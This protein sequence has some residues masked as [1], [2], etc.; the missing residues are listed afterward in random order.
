M[1]AVIG[2]E[3]DFEACDFHLRWNLHHK[4]REWQ[5]QGRLDPNLFDKEKTAQWPAS[6]QDAFRPPL[7]NTRTLGALGGIIASRIA[8]EFRFG[9]PS[10]VVSSEAVS[11]LKALEIGVRSLQRNEI[12]AVLVG[13]VDLC[14]DVR[15]VTVSN[16]IRTFTQNNIIRP[17]DASADGTLPGE[18]AAAVVLKRLDQAVTD[19]DRIYS[20]VKGLGDAVGGKNPMPSKDAIVLSLKRA[21]KDAGISPSAVSLIETHGSGSPIEDRMESEALVEVFNGKELSIAVGS[22]KPNIGHTGAAAGLASMVKTSLCLYQ[23]IIP[24]L[25][26]Y[27]SPASS[28]WQNSPF[29]MPASA[30]YWVRNRSDGPR[31]ACISAM[32]LDGNCMHVVLEGVEYDDVDRDFDG[33][34]D[35]VTDKVV[36]ER[37]RPLGVMA[38]GLFVVEGNTEGELLEGLFSLS[39]HVQTSQDSNRPASSIKHHEAMDGHMESLAKSWYLKSKPE[40]EKPLAL[41]IVAENLTKLETYIDDA[42]T[43]VSTQTQRHMN[44]PGGVSY[45]PSPLGP[46][47]ETAFVYP[48]SGNHYVGMGRGIG[49]LW[50]EILRKM[51]AETSR[52]KTQL[53]PEVYIPRRTSWEGGWETEALQKI[54]SDPLNMIFGQVVHGTVMTRLA[55]GFGIRPHAVIGYSLGESAGLFAMGVWPDRGRMLKRM[56]DTN[57]F[58]TE[59][60]GPCHSARNA[61]KIPE[62]EAVNWCAAVVNRSADRVLDVIADQPFVKLLIIN[63]PDQCVIGGR[64]PNVQAVIQ[65]LKCEAVFLDG[66]VTVHCDASHPV[67]EDYKNLHL[68]PT[69][70]TE[71][72]RFYS[73]ALGRAYRPT[74]ES[75]AK[76]ILDQALSGFNFTTLIE[77]AYGDGVRIFLEMGPHASCTGMIKTILKAKPHLALSACSRGEDDLLTILKCLGTLTAHRVPVDL[78]TLYG[79]HA[80]TPTAHEIR[81]QT[82]GRRMTLPVGGKIPSP[83]LPG[84]EA[85]SPRLN[86][87]RSS[88]SKNLTG[89]AEVGRRRQINR[90]FKLPEQ[91]DTFNQQSTI[92]NHKSKIDLLPPNAAAGESRKPDAYIPYRN[93]MDSLTESTQATAKAHQAFLEFSNTITQGFEKTFETQSKLLE[94]LISEEHLQPQ[95]GPA[96]Q[97][98]GKSDSLAAHTEKRRIN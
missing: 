7:N 11:G 39:L 93:L 53:I 16:Q 47:G 2:I 26:N 23:E 19:K 65:N 28:I 35:R 15:S 55:R 70:P 98:N 68:F 37:K 62:H 30:Q 31:R 17:F 44:G 22:V 91:S 36:L 78:D 29:Y 63:T 6:L 89:Q 61:W 88:S 45:S 20:V 83:V 5:K 66:V 18:G 76:S 32:T 9:G 74:R 49:V 1:G 97:P 13:A 69:T 25:N 95:T 33:I 80:W 94:T 34:A 24:P 42:K 54:V 12:D 56:L 14:G 96:T 41:S 43:A 46:S 92:N 73:C 75:A 57:L 52:L 27:V 4:V 67:A 48:G 84:K 90:R 21:F 8:R 38:P 71:D 72:I 64:K 59:L 87:L 86:S 58:S 81:T 85:G 40:L 60:A 3:F 51:D 50:P 82:P 79:I 10:F 77:Q